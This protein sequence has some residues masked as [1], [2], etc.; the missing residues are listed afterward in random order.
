[1]A[2]GESVSALKNL[3]RKFRLLGGLSVV[4]LTIEEELFEVGR[5]MERRRRAGIS[6]HDEGFAERV[7]NS[8]NWA[9]A[10]GFSIPSRNYYLDE[11][12][13]SLNGRK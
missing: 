13:R 1:M 7:A 8:S 3:I 2:T 6:I 4:P 12:A 11:G 10:S 5:E 9:M